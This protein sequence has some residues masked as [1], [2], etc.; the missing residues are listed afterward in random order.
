MAS[1]GELEAS[2]EGWGSDV[3]RKA[4]TQQ[5]CS[6]SR[7]QDRVSSCMLGHMAKN[8]GTSRARTTSSLPRVAPC[9]RWPS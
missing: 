8:G 2:G 6:P 5:G 9:L 7:E 3:Q 1:L 4:Q